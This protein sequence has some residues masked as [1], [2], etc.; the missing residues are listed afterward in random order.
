MSGFIDLAGRRFGR[1]T[2][3]ALHPRRDVNVRWL[4]EC[5]CGTV[6]PV[7]GGSLRGGRSTSC[8]CAWRR[9]YDLNREREGGR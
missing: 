5:D 4:C 3:L 7:L 6:R 8:G 9:H 1:W 2:V